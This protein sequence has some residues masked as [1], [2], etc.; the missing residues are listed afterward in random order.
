MELLERE[1]CLADLTA[2]FGAATE[3]EGCIALVRGEAFD[4]PGQI[5][6]GTP[7]VARRIAAI[8]GSL[9]SSAHRSIL[10]LPSARPENLLMTLEGL[11]STRGRTYRLHVT[12]TPVRSIANEEPS[13]LQSYLET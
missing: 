3:R 6:R 13:T 8:F 1:Q 10:A 4:A 9:I 2:W 12:F 7:L 11:P 5:A